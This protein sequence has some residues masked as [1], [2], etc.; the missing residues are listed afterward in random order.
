LVLRSVRL[1][2]YVHRYR[3]KLIVF[4]R[5]RAIHQYAAGKQISIP[6]LHLS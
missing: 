5:F 6:L 4:V 2:V 3:D 1:G